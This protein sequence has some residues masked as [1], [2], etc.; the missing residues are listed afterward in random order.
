VGKTR[1]A[2]EAM[3]RAGAAGMVMVRGECLPLAEALPLLPVAGAVG[4]L[5]RVDD[6]GLVD[7]ALDA[8]PEY[9][10]KEVGRLV[11]GLAP[12]G[13]RGAVGGR[14]DGW[15]RGRLFSA[16]AELLDAAAGCRDGVGVVIEDVHWA[17]SATL[18]CLTFVVRGGCRGAVG[19]VVTCRGDE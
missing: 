10:R 7:A 12:E 18:D 17:D 3:V 8:V 19:V 15:R 1:F 2:G 5:A 11:P 16:V 9:V 14:D 13:G 4:E 6:G